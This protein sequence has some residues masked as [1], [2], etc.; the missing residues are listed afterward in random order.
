MRAVEVDQ[1]MLVGGKMR[2]D[3]VEN[4]TDTKLVQM[5]DEIHQVFRRAIARGGRKVTRGLIS[6]GAVKRMLRDGHELDMGEAE[7]LEVVAQRMRKFPI[8][9]K[10]AVLSAPGSEMHFVDRHGC[11]QAIA[12]HPRSHPRTILPGVIQCP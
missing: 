11:G 5:I 8:T 2:G 1:A 10:V 6:P 4:N 9:E 3:P 12:R 7:V